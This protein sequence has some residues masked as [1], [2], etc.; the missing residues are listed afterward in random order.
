MPD[1]PWTLFVEVADG[2][3]AD[4]L[5]PLADRDVV[6][7]TAPT[8]QRRLWEVREGMTDAW[9]RAATDAGTV[10]QKFDVSLP[11]ARL[12]AFA[13]AVRD[14]IPTIGMFGHVGDGNLH[15]EV[16]DADRD[17][18]AE[19]LATV[20]Q[21]RG[22]ISAEHGIGQAKRDYLHLSRSAAEIAA[23]RAIKRALDPAGVMNP[24]VLLPT[25]PASAGSSA[26][27][28]RGTPRGRPA[29]AGRRSTRHRVAQTSEAASPRKGTPSARG[30]AGRYVPSTTMSSRSP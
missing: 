29:R 27:A 4:G 6:V 30:H 1:A 21:H 22:S 3:T 7:A 5:E 23:M 14:L 28:P 25:D 17:W 24:G 18:D 10:V 2:G 13:D 26:P 16:I 20:A 19:V 8:E 9:G 11:S 15:L 12:D